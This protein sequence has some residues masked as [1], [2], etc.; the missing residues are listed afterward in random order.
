MKENENKGQQ[1]FEDTLKEQQL[2]KKEKNY[3]I[4]QRKGITKIKRIRNEQG[5]I[6]KKI[7]NSG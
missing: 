3:L 5:N 2:T 1:N 6:F 4:T 7:S